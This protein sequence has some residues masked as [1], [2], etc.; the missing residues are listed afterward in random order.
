MSEEQGYAERSEDMS[1]TGK[2]RVFKEDDGD[3]IVAIVKGDN[4][5]DFVMAD[6]EFCTPGTGG[7]K[8]PHTRRALLELYDAIERDNYESPK[9]RGEQ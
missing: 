3:V 2:L 4:E 7:G 6:A 8:S 9:A 5:K 1:P